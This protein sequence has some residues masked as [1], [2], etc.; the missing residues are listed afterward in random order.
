MPKIPIVNPASNSTQ[1]DMLRP[2]CCP[3]TYPEFSY[4]YDQVIFVVPT[5]KLDLL[6]VSDA[7]FC[8]S[9]THTSPI[10]VA[11]VI[12]ITYHISMNWNF[13]IQYR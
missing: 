9:L 11:D 10:H 12:R 4:N 8:E 6:S 1:D 7:N 13:E 3:G 2:V 5:K